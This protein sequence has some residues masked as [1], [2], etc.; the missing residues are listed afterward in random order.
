MHR[1][2][3]QGWHKI[4][5]EYRIPP[6]IR[7][8][9]I[10]E[11]FV[12]YS[13]ETLLLLFV[14]RLPRGS[15]D[16]KICFFSSFLVDL[17]SKATRFPCGLKISTAI[18]DFSPNPSQHIWALARFGDFLK[19]FIGFSSNSRV[20]GLTL[21][22]TIRTNH[23]R[24]IRKNKVFMNYLQIYSWEFVSALAWPY[25]GILIQTFKEQLPLGYCDLNN[26]WVVKSVK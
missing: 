16:E 19:I 12:N 3:G 7:Y 6:T 14:R 5:R 23:L 1:G 18:L 9:S 26:E 8:Y 17:G 2:G 22:G 25:L 24:I 10:H 11:L 15:R 21:P 4:V 13:F 20:V